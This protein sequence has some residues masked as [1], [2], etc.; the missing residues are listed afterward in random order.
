MNSLKNKVQLLGHIGSEVVLKSTEKGANYL[1]LS[2]AVDASY[3]DKEGVKVD[4]ADWFNLTM[5]NKTAELAGQYIA[6]GDKVLI[7][8][9]LTNNSY[10]DKD[11]NNRNSTIISVNEFQV[12]NSK[13]KP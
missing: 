8:G 5:W 4:K 12:I 13:I 7:S 9:K 2:I 1:N 6:K 3:K 11:G 10:T